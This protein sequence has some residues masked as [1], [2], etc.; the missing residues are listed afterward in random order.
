M[1]K[2]FD[3]PQGTLGF[4]LLKQAELFFFGKTK[5]RKPE[6][7]INTCKLECHLLFQ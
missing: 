5:A 3:I 6:L 1:N 7:K 2:A 4:R